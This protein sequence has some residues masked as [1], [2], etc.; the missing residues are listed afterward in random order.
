[1]K[2]K[3]PEKK[4]YQAYAVVYKD[5]NFVRIYENIGPAK[6]YISSQPRYNMKPDEQ[7]KVMKKYKIIGLVAAGT[8]ISGE[9]HFNDRRAKELKKEIRSLKRWA[10]SASDIAKKIELDKRIDK[11]EEE[12]YDIL[13][14]NI[15]AN[16]AQQ[17]GS[18]APQ[19]QN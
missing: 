9:E 16:Q 10:S 7:K 3:N 6:S 8:I 1:M 4:Q 17:Q 12:L 18:A 15:K 14:K 11:Y 2:I 19:V 13:S 5:N